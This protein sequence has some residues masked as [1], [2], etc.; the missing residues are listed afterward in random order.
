MLGIYIGGAKKHKT[1]IM[2]D[3]LVNEPRDPTEVSFSRLKKEVV[4]IK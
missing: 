2:V 3:E 4:D 1:L